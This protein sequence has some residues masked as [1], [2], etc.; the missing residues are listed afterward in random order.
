M[1]IT[2]EE[3]EKLWGENGPY[4]Q[5]QLIFETRIL[6]DRISRTFLIIEIQINPFTF[7]LIRKNRTE[8]ADDP[9]IQGILDK[10]EYRGQADGYVACAFQEEYY[11]KLLKRANDILGRCEKTIIKMHKFVL[12]E[13]R[14]RE[15]N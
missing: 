14:I 2:R 13:L 6:D 15:M 5:A 9:L 4:S 11:A 7:E 8:F 12:K 1:P 10:S 3:S